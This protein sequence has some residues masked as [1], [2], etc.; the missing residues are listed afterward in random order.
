[1]KDYILKAVFIN[2]LLLGT[3]FLAPSVQAQ[4]PDTL[5]AAQELDSLVESEETVIE[6]TEEDLSFSDIIAAADTLLSSEGQ[7]ILEGKII[8]IDLY[9]MRKLK[10]MLESKDD[11]SLLNRYHDLEE[12][13]T[14]L[15]KKIELAVLTTYTV[16]EWKCLREDYE[17]EREETMEYIEALTDSLVLTYAPMFTCS[18]GKRLLANVEDQDKLVEDFYYRLGVL[19]LEQAELHYERESFAW[20]D[21]VDSLSF[22]P[23]AEIPPEPVMDYSLATSRFEEMLDRFPDSEYSDDALYSLAYI[24]SRSSDDKVKLSGVALLEEFSQ[25]YLYSPYYPEVEMRLGEYYFNH[26]DSKT[27]STFGIVDAAIRHYTEVLNYPEEP[28]YSNALYRLGWAYYLKDEYEGAIKYFTRTIDETLEKMQRGTYSNLMEESIENLSQ[29]FVT[30][31]ETTYAGI[32]SAVEFLRDDPMRLELFGDQMI[33]RIGDIYQNDMADFQNAIQAYDTLLMIF[34]NDPKAPEIQ[35]QKIKCYESMEVVDRERVMEE[36]YRLFEMFNHTS[37][38]THAQSDSQ[39]AKKANLLAE[40]NLR[41]IV[42]ESIKLSSETNEQE[43]YEKAVKLSQTYVDYYPNTTE[44]YRIHNNYAA[45]LTLYMNDYLSALQENINVTRKYLMGEYH[46]QCA[47]DAVACA[48]KLMDM[49]KAG[50]VILPPKEEIEIEL[51]PDVI[52]RIP[53][54]GDNPLL[55]SEVLYFYTVQNYLDLFP[56]GKHC[57]IY[58]L[59]AG[60]L[61]YRHER[62]ADSRYYLERLKNDF[63][64]SPKWEETC[65]IILEG[66]FISGDYASSEKLSKELRAQAGDLSPE[67]KALAESR[68]GESIYKQGKSYED[69]GEFVRAGSEYKRVA[70]ESPRVDFADDALWESGR[71]FMNAAAKDSAALESG[72]VST[73]W[74]SAIVSFDLLAV[75][76][77]NSEWSVKSLNNIAFIYQNNLDDKIKAASGFERLYDTYRDSANA[78]RALINAGVNYTELDSFDAALRVNEKYLRAFGEDTDDDNVI[79]ILYDNAEL[80]L[81][82]GNITRAINAFSDFTRKFPNDPRNVRAEYQIGKYY[83]DKGDI[84]RAKSSF[85]RTVEVHKRLVDKGEAGFPRYASF[86]KSKLLEWD[87]S[88]FVSVEYMPLSAVESQRRRKESLK[89]S[90]EEGYEELISFRQKEAIQALYNVCRLDEEMAW[91]ELNQSIPPVSADKAMEQR[92]EILDKSLPLYIDA[93]ATYYTIGREI[94]DWIKVLNEQ[95]LKIPRR[96]AELDSILNAEGFLPPDLQVE[97]EAKQGDLKEVEESLLIAET[98]K[99]SCTYK[100]AQIYYNNAR[101]VEEVLDGYYAMPDQGENRRW[102]MYYRASVLGKFAA[103]RVQSVV[104]LYLQACV[105]ADTINAQ[106]IWQDSAASAAG[107][108]LDKL[109][110]E[111]YILIER[112]MKRYRVNLTAF[113]QRVREGD[114]SAVTIM[115]SPTL[116]LSFADAFIDSMMMNMGAVLELAHRDTAGTR[117]SEGIDSIY[118]ESVW[119]YFRQYTD[120]INTNQEYFDSYTRK[121]EQTGDEL[122]FEGMD[123]FEIVMDYTKEYQLELLEH[124]TEYIENYGII[125]ETGDGVIREMVK[126]DP[127]GYGYLLGLSLDKGELVAGNSEWRVAMEADREFRGLDFDDSGWEFAKV[128]E[129]PVLE[130]AVEDTTTAIEVDTAVVVEDTSITVEID[131]TAAVEDSAAADSLFQYEE[132]TVS[133]TA[134]VLG[135]VEPEEE[136]LD[137]SALLEMGVQAISADT[138]A[139]KL[140]FRHKFTIK[141]IPIAGVVTISADDKFSLF[142]NGKFV[143]KGSN[144]EMAW[145]TPV[146]YS[147]KAFLETG[148]N[149]IAVEVTDPDLSGNGLWFKLQYNVMPENIDDLPIVRVTGR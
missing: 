86:A 28:Q 13:F 85:K 2:I 44:T 10:P 73:V 92:E 26:P 48:F 97:K 42:D 25:R 33:R 62:Y 129:L 100:I 139:E 133:D 89:Q 77:P 93:A 74:D 147:V 83:L 49:E 136:S 7:L 37:S 35:R 59:S 110:Q 94:A 96:I 32:G 76:Y 4:E 116:Y 98:L 146:N 106:A 60:V 95:Q 3:A 51:P 24:M 124:A 78:R 131:T 19:Y 122:Y 80:Y 18:K 11:I 111:Y 137:F 118:T 17:L 103:P 99:D 148:E 72:A 107:A 30:G 68:V 9:E 63:K 38:W 31:T 82:K 6:F 27:D 121:Y 67:L 66:Y 21:L 125:T 132:G 123:L 149:I 40:K 112:P 57:D 109:A 127:V 114:I 46:E 90:M 104:S 143:G 70:M 130:E 54:L 50:G 29:S 141:D 91:A 14:G 53:Y 58:L 22:F 12:R 65:K 64:D 23:D 126:R 145:L 88:E 79:R 120:I 105:T 115:S 81:N 47:D 43:D 135:A 15:L 87:L 113:R 142:I 52:A 84:S 39:L 102:K 138:P 45:M 61:Y 20:D 144:D 41:E 34:P 36:R 55:T 56:K 8:A 119:N 140:Y 71:Q 108:V 1:M 16:D 117:F 75:N 134:E 128:I 69:R 101:Y 5:D